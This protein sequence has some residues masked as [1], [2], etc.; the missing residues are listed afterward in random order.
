MSVGTKL[1][2]G[3]KWTTISTIGR[4]LFQLI[5]ISILTRFL[6][7][8]D[9]GLVAMAGV[10]IN[11]TNVFAE[12]GFT[13]A[14]LHKQ[15]PTSNEYSSI[16]WTN[17]VISLLLY[18]IL[19][20]L[21]PFAANFYQDSR[22]LNII[23]ILGVNLIISSIGKLHI[24]IMQ[25]NFKFKFISL[26][27]LTSIVVGVIT[28]IVLAMNHYGI[29][30]LII[31]S[32]IA[33]SITTFLAL[34]LSLSST[35][36]RFYFKL[37]DLRD[38][39]KVGG[40]TFGSQLLSFFTNDIDTLIIGRL[41]GAETLGLYN[42][43]KNIAVKVYSIVNPIV[44]RV[45][46]PILAELQN[47]REI[48][49]DNYLKVVSYLAYINIPIYLMIVICSKELL[50]FLYGGDYVSGYVILS[51]MAIYYCAN[52]INNPVGSLQIATGRT[53]I[54][55]KWALFCLIVYPAA[56][57]L[58]APLG[59]NFVAISRGLLSVI[60]I[61]PLWRMQLRIMIG[62]KLKEFIVIFAKPLSIFLLFT[63]LYLSFTST[64]ILIAPIIS[65]TVKILVVL[66]LYYSVLF[67]IDKENLKLK[68]KKIHSLVNLKR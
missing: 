45:L 9:F 16:Y 8:E 31:S 44:M 51:F 24:T 46:T 57:F 52:S 39:F 65:L 22:L 61:Y 18:L 1:F 47:D 29:Y 49:K 10:V 26:I 33:T 12:L 25:K 14:V 64:K 54:G 56:I 13:S 11:F 3:T 21:T 28:A 34:L 53:D 62:I 55:L 43:S 4:S 68:Y 58:T 5:Q 15:A 32:L 48:L 38:Y 19:Y 67:L 17:I 2:A 60:L 42:L 35:P 36:I 7:K 23:P 37:N 66:L 59:I 41:L 63:V 40:F 27:E 6:V 20:L 50:F 30:S